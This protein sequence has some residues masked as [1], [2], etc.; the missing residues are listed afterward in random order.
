MR[1]LVVDDDAGLLA[2]IRATFEDVDA[3][4]E[5]AGSARAARQTVFAKPPD[6][7]VLDVMLAGD[8]GLDL[9]CELKADLRTAAIPIVLL[10]GSIDLASKHAA[11]SGA[12]A[13]MEKP[14][15]PLHLL[16]VVEQLAGGLGTFPFLEAPIEKSNNAQLLLYAR[17]LRR[18]VEL[19]RAQRRLLQEAYGATVGA[20]AEALGTKDTG[21]RAHSSRVQRYASELM[22]VVEPSLAE[23]TSVE[24]GFL[25]HDVGKIGISDRILQKIGPLSPEERRVMEQHP[26]LGHD[27][28][29]GITFLQG[30]G[31]AVVRSHHERYDGRGYPDRLSGNG[32]PLAARIFA[33]ADALDAMT[34]D[35]PYRRAGSWREA[36]AEIARE[37]GGQ[38]DPQVVSAFQEAQ[39][40]LQ[41]LR[42]AVA[43]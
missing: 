38:F 28:L 5:V 32:I 14:F 42:V 6:V 39:P 12:D 27:M 20:L 3:E 25:L 19:E 16:E 23:D 35:R 26:I 22:R 31:L 8:S 2:L 24:Y 43:A 34:S 10:S 21:T 18:I 15:S 40:R 41:D 4:V 33:V 9:C 30:E 37:S 36:A 17:D 1:L 13:Y 11:E 29:R 7:I